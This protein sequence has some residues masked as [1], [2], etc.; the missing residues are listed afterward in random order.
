VIDPINGKFSGYAWAQNY[1]YIKFN[2]SDS[3]YCVKTDWR[4]YACSNGIDDDSDENQVSN[5]EDVEADNTNLQH[6]LIQ[7]EALSYAMAG[8]Y[9]KSSEQHFEIKIDY[10]IKHHSRQYQMGLVLCP[11]SIPKMLKQAMTY[12]QRASEFIYNSLYMKKSSFIGFKA[13]DLGYGLFS[14]IDIDEGT[15][16][17]RYKG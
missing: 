12:R 8:P 10:L 4:P 17:G 6:N 9:F 1:G 16:I 14:N 7:S 11:K 13:K 15:T 2:C 3:N 5:I